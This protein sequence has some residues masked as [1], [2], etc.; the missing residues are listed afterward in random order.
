[1]KCFMEAIHVLVRN[2][3]F[4]RHGLG[5]WGEHDQFWCALRECQMRKECYDLAYRNGAYGSTHRRKQ[6]SGVGYY[7]YLRYFGAL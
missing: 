3:H 4:S 2:K 7:A 1:M 6:L 5:R